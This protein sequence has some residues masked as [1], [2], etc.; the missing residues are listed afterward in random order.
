MRPAPQLHLFLMLATAQAYIENSIKDGLT[1]ETMHH[2]ISSGIKGWLT[3]RKLSK[4]EAKLLVR[5][6]ED[7]YMQ[8]LK[9]VEISFIV[10]ALEIL[11]MAVEEYDFNIGV[12]KKK[13]LRG[14]SVFVVGMLQTK[15]KDKEKYDRLKAIIDESTIV[16][17]K[18][19][20]YTQERIKELA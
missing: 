19:Y 15:R 20:G 6:G 14:K 4:E 17:K 5:L 18:F 7:E 8:K 1:D 9:E 11:R 10:Y 13:L 12:G 2:Q 16:A 3:F